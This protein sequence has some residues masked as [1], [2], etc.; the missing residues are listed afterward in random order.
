MMFSVLALHKVLTKTNLAN[1]PVYNQS[2]VAAS[3][4]SRF[5]DRILGV[6]LFELKQAMCH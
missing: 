1:G 3:V 6:R 4:D 2:W 5:Y